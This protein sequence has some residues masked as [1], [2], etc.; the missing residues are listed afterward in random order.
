M[1]PGE[2]RT[3][4]GKLRRALEGGPGV[5]LVCDLSPATEPDLSVVDA[6]A[7]LALI[8]RRCQRPVVVRHACPELWDLL[9]LAGLTALPGIDLEPGGKPEQREPPGG[10]QEE[11][12]PRDPIA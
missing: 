9:T 5:V 1:R 3:L 11:R 12:D 4:C 7:R 2:I 6:L 8:A 10:V